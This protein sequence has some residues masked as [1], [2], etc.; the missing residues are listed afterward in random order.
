MTSNKLVF[1]K[2]LLV[3]IFAFFFIVFSQNVLAT[4]FIVE[5]KPIKDR[6]S[7]DEVA[8]FNITITNLLDTTTSYS[9]SLNLADFNYWVSYPSAILV[10]GGSTKSFVFNIVPKPATPIGVYLVNPIFR[11]QQSKQNIPL[12]IHLSYD[13]LFFDFVPNVQA[14]IKLPETIDPRN[15][16]RVSVSLRNRNPLNIEDAELRIISDLFNGVETINIGPLQEISQKEFFFTLDPL[17][18]PGTYDVLVQ[19][20]YPRVDRV[21]ASARDVV[22]IEG[23]SSTPSK[24]ETSKKLFVTTNNI[25]VENFGNKPATAEVMLSMSSF[26]KLFSKTSPEAEFVKTDGGSNFLWRP[27][28]EPT[29]KLTIIVRTNYWPLVIF[30]ILVILII[31]L[32]FK[33]RSPIVLEKEAVVIDED[34]GEGS[35]DIRIRLF[36][37]NRTSN[38]V[39]SISVSDRVIGITEYVESNQLGHVKP[40]RVTKTSKKGTLLYWDLEELEAYEERIFTYKI[41]SKL[42]VVGNLTLPKFKVKFEARGRERQVFSSKPYFR[43]AKKKTK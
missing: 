30:S 8:S 31:F 3:A 41:K 25:L 11:S 19:V 15:S 16:A 5:H 23:Y 26:R 38:P 29:E 22:T 40:S 14:E 9:V 12:S 24:I 20:Y 36:L 28:L 33:L 32:Y 4:D 13:G 21:I 37:R 17:Q 27:V 6:I 2:A 39:K 43:K 7:P 1:S 10:E 42:K 34:I 35:S 18:N